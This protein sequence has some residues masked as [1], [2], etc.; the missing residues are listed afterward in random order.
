MYFGYLLFAL[1]LLVQC[2]GISDQDILR[3]KTTI[4]MFS[5]Q[6]SLRVPAD[7][8]IIV[9]PILICI[10]QFLFFA[11]LYKVR[12]EQKDAGF[13]EIDE[14]QFYILPYSNPYFYTTGRLYYLILQRIE[15]LLTWYIYSLINIV[16]VIKVLKFQI[17]YKYY[18]NLLILAL[19]LL[20]AS[21]FRKYHM[22]R[23]PKDSYLFKI[24][25]F[26]MKLKIYVLKIADHIRI[27]KEYYF[28]NTLSLFC[29]LAGSAISLNEKWQL[30][31]YEWQSLEIKGEKI[32]PEIGQKYSVYFEG[33]DFMFIKILDSELEGVYFKN[34]NLQESLF[35]NATIAN[36]RFEMVDFSQ[37]KFIDSTFINTDLENIKTEVIYFQN[38]E[39]FSVFGK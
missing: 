33:R 22:L 20:I 24:E 28:M 14:F 25:S 18:I 8:F 31:A 4:L 34:S 13:Q 30:T 5:S 2:L 12:E 16:F 37:S 21:L 19:T 15:N 3:N 17:I 32:L 38:T 6:I 36:S 29:L 23:Y 35:Q 39:G 10:I 11:T 27:Y 26:T 9:A 1:I 7:I